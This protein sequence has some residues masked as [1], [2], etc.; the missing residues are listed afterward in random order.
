MMRAIIGLLILL[1]GVLLLT[2]FF[3]TGIL[4]RMIFN[5]FR[6]WP[7]FFVFIGISILSSIKGLR[8]MKYINYLLG[9]FFAIYIVF[10][11]LE[12]RFFDFNSE[13]RN[14]EILNTESKN[15]DIDIDYPSVVLA[16]EVKD[17]E[18]ISIEYDSDDLKPDIKILNDKIK[19]DYDDNFLKGTNRYITLVLP[20][21][22]NY[23]IDI[24]SAYADLRV[25]DN[26]SSI[27]EI[28]FDTAI[29][30]LYY[31][32]QG[33]MK[34]LKLI[35]NSAIFKADIDVLENTRYDYNKSTAIFT[36]NINGMNRDRDMP[37]LYLDINTAISNIDIY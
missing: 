7:I 17:I 8:W 29:T 6:L 33:D 19:I 24:D 3:N 28:H 9:I 15:V 36:R 22:K 16:I 32:N 10:M 30:R 27:N 2:G 25:K 31:E 26:Y 4:F 34:Y 5:F 18:Q 20:K 35:S 1:I 11:P 14:F 37:Q 23:K 13:N 12:S 21:D